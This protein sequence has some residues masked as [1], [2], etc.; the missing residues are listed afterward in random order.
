MSSD[1]DEQVLRIWKT[2]YGGLHTCFPEAGNH[3]K[4][5]MKIFKVVIFPIDS[6]S[7]PHLQTTL[8]SLQD[9]SWQSGDQDTAVVISV[10]AECSGNYELV[11]VRFF[12]HANIH[13]W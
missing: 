12:V 1:S 2:A 6:P 4:L 7:A 9:S 13:Q 8:S 5:E 10:S 11:S 3:D